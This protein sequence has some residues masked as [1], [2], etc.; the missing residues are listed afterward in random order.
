MS[1][2]NE[3]RFV[4]H[5]MESPPFSHTYS[6]FGSIRSVLTGASAHRT[7]IQRAFD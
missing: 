4:A 5:S 6:S 2:A 7:L 3:A 1:R